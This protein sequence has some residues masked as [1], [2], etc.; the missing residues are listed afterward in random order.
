[1]VPDSSRVA[2]RGSFSLCLSLHK[3][4]GRCRWKSI[5]C[6]NKTLFLLQNNLFSRRENKFSHRK[7]IF[8]HREKLFSRREN[9]LFA[10]F[11]YLCT[12]EKRINHQGKAI[13]LSK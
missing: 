4:G 1:M 11:L 9:N 6:P 12:I 7:N 8:S 3:K 10:I 2:K 13:L 5:L